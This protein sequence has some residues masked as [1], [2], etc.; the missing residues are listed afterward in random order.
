MPLSFRDLV[1][2][3]NKSPSDPNSE[4]AE[5]HRDSVSSEPS[6]KDGAAL[7]SSPVSLHGEK[8]KTT[9]NN[10]G[11]KKRKA[12]S[13]KKATPKSKSSRKIKGKQ[14]AAWKK[15]ISNSS[16]RS[17]G[18]TDDDEDNAR[19]V[20]GVDE[21]SDQIDQEENVDTDSFNN[22]V[23][24]ARIGQIA[25]ARLD[26]LYSAL[27]S[28]E[29]LSSSSS[30]LFRTD[31]AS[32]RAP[33]PENT[34]SSLPEE[35][36]QQQEVTASDYQ[37]TP[38]FLGI[39]PHVKS[40]QFPKVRPLPEPK[41]KLKRKAK[42]R[43]SKRKRGDDDDSSVEEASVSS[44]E[45]KAKTA[46]EIAQDAKKQKKLDEI[47]RLKYARAVEWRDIRRRWK[48]RKFDLR[49]ESDV[50]GALRA[51]A[52]N[53]RPTKAQVRARDQTTDKRHEKK[54]KKKRNVRFADKLKSDDKV[55]EGGIKE[56]EESEK[57]EGVDETRSNVLNRL[58]KKQ[59]EQ[60]VEKTE[61]VQEPENLEP[62]QE[63]LDYWEMGLTGPKVDPALYRTQPI[64]KQQH[65]RTTASRAD[66]CEQG[67]F[68]GLR[69]TTHIP[70]YSRK[71][72]EDSRRNRVLPPL[73]W[74][75]TQQQH[76][77][78]ILRLASRFT[79]TAPRLTGNEAIVANRL[80][81]LLWTQSMRDYSWRV[82][83]NEQAKNC[84]RRLRNFLAYKARHPIHK[85]EELGIT[86]DIG[87]KSRFI[88]DSSVAVAIS[89][90][91]RKAK[92]RKESLMQVSVQY[93][94]VQGTS[95]PEPRLP[96]YALGFE[97]GP[98]DRFNFVFHSDRVPEETEK[99]CL[100]TIFARWVCT[101]IDDVSRRGFLENQLSV[102]METAVRLN[103]SK[104][105]NTFKTQKLT[106]DE[107]PQYSFYRSLMNFSSLLANTGGQNF[108]CFN[109][110][111]D[112]EK[113]LDDDDNY[114][115]TNASN[116]FKAAS[117]QVFD[118]IE[119]SIRTNGLQA[120]PRIHLMYA[121]VRIS[122]EIPEEGVKILSIPLH[123]NPLVT[124][125][126]VVRNMLE[127]LDNERI[128]VQSKQHG[129]VDVNKLENA[130]LEAS[131]SLLTCIEADPIE[132]EYHAWHVAFKAAC[133][134]LSSGNFIGG[135]ARLFPSTL[136]KRNAADL[137]S[138]MIDNTKSSK[139]REHE[140]RP[141][142]KNFEKTRVDTAKAFRLLLSLA[143]H[144]NE[145][146]Y[147]DCVAGF[148]EWRQVVALLVGDADQK[149]LHFTEI[150][151][152]H[153]ECRK[154]WAGL[155]RSHIGKTYLNHASDTEQVLVTLADALERAPDNVLNWRRLVRA[156]GALNAVDHRELHGSQ[157]MEETTSGGI[158]RL[159]VNGQ[160]KTQ[161]DFKGQIVQSKGAPVTAR[162]G[163]CGMTSEE[164][165]ILPTWLNGRISWW[166]DQLLQVNQPR[167]D[168]K[169]YV[170]GLNR[171]A[172]HILKK[173]TTT[174]KQG[175]FNTSKAS[176]ASAVSSS[177]PWYESV[178]WLKSCLVWRDTTAT[179]SS[180][181]YKQYDHVLPQTIK[182][183]LES[184]ACIDFEALGEPFPALKDVSLKVELD[185]YKVML[186][187]HIYGSSDPCVA[188]TVK[189]YLHSVWRP[190]KK[191]MKTKSEFWRALEW[192][193][194][195]G[196]DI[197]SNLPTPP[198][199]VFSREMRDVVL[200]EVSECG[201][202]NWK[203]IQ[204]KHPEIFEG[205]HRH[206]ARL[207]YNYLVQ[208][209]ETEDRR[210]VKP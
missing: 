210:Q 173:N 191:Q 168:F 75:F 183:V 1:F 125:Y 155:E 167:V 29:T 46:D 131:N 200:K 132:P 64:P 94:P 110:L 122:K 202:K 119:P 81:R 185:C 78:Q 111:E 99:L 66:T 19:N 137:L 101:D 136:T 14:T 178:G 204:K 151:R 22:P 80:L 133:M 82:V 93:V 129:F 86:R 188:E 176:G 208:I 96:L 154:R 127:Y 164:E 91:E 28:E 39:N 162:S 30:R 128:L 63:R 181:I 157:N 87:L 174:G 189:Y 203:E 72:K 35:V 104:V 52:Q 147:H 84:G 182:E 31:A 59:A 21:E 186:R 74:T 205:R 23:D 196:V 201:L 11:A 195:M 24:V 2:G 90:I 102:M 166:S 116:G 145:A 17:E 149:E 126:T 41:P 105:Q 170:E 172:K 15:T 150:R 95:P 123:G 32:P 153:S 142:L 43:R 8:A 56:M 45:E 36:T 97:F 160:M 85:M 100:S 38:F 69:L 146:R 58:V 98:T 121:L 4:K 20:D 71:A 138:D 139:E 88:K 184:P 47:K 27:E 25:I 77:H 10:N 67:K 37:S 62:Y 141:M 169:G 55:L 140:A 207:C 143:K 148:L 50:G 103:D 106:F 40:S 6:A 206:T 26:A 54:T 51:L 65:G 193:H 61:E 73:R 16:D 113:Q 79:V 114:E 161:T 33:K 144:H 180:E 70:K 83:M 163:Y 135:A 89:K 117:Q 198:P 5:K 13:G 199:N 171:K 130:F 107:I 92:P 7:H 53:N 177:T 152:L 112:T 34:P 156:L 159:N 76:R 12:P 194:T 49:E 42:R 3:G 175:F 18:S 48:N 108:V 179:G 118:T 68:P 209:G 134:I 124:P 187:C 197:V 120:F 165:E 115:Q 109:E 9:S 44:E 60:K 57:E 190:K 158:Q 192:L